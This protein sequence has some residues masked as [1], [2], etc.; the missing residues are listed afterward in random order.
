[1]Y[2][3]RFSISETTLCPPI[4]LSVRYKRYG[5]KVNFPAVITDRD[6]ISIYVF[7]K[8]FVRWS[9][10]KASMSINVYIY[11]ISIMYIQRFSDLICV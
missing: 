6:M 5:E 3:Q 2:K 7:H 9:V 1:M 8:S 4:C 11:N 10:R